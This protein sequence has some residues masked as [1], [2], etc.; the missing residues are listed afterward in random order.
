MSRKTN[1]NNKLSKLI[2]EFEDAVQSFSPELW[3]EKSFLKLIS[4]YEN[5]GSFDRAL[6][7]ADLAI[8]QYKYRVDFYLQ[9][10]D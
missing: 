8:K 10:P 4:H 5:Q 7:V 9:K 2:A 3:E 1:Q 6:A